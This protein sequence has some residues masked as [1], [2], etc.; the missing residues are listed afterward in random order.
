MTPL[1]REGLRF[2][3]I[4]RKKAFDEIFIQYGR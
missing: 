4:S 2:S 3:E 1:Q